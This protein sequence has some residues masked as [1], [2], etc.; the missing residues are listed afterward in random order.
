[1]TD[2]CHQFS[3]YS[4]TKKIE[5]Y[6]LL[7][8]LANAFLYIQTKACVVYELTCKTLLIALYER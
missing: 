4:L 6:N 1:M 2:L 5:N 8:N 3:M 7:L